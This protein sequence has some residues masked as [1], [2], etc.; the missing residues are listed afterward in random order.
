MCKRNATII[1]NQPIAKVRLSKSLNHVVSV[2]V[3]C[4]SA[5]VQTEGKG[6]N[7]RQSII[8]MDLARNLYP[9]IPWGGSHH[10]YDAYEVHAATWW[11]I[12]T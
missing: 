3:L 11:G 9:P 2:T 8:T 7:E 10:C 1:Y 4:A 6:K 5:C 12:H